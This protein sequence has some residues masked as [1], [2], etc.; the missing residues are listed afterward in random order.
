MRRSSHSKVSENK[1]SMVNSGSSSDIREDPY[2][3]SYKGSWAE[4]DDADEVKSC[5][6][7]SRST[8]SR[9]SKSYSMQTITKKNSSGWFCEKLFILVYF[10]LMLEY[11]EIRS[12]MAYERR[13]HDRKFF[14]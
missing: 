3:S 4:Y 14:P 13:S 11:S 10:N 12:V 8:K 2:S 7:S 6:S 1:S 9:I 5:G